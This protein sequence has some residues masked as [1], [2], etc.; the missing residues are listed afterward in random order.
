MSALAEALVAAQARALAALQKAYVAG[1]VDA[2]HVHTQLAELGI[3]D[4]VDIGRLIACLDVIRELGS[5]V[6]AEPN[7]TKRDDPVTAPQL[8]LIGKL[9]REKKVEQPE[10]AGM[11]KAKASDVIGELQA[12]TYDPAKWT[13][14]F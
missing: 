9:C 5:E 10:Y 1:A 2:D 4:G 12:G 7:G 6:P 14:P 3:T 8:Q 13:V 11:T